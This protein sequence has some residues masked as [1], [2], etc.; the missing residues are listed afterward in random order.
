MVVDRVRR[1]RHV[2]R[3]RRSRQGRREDDI[4]RLVDAIGPGRDAVPGA[5]DE[6]TRLGALLVV[7]TL[8]QWAGLRGDSENSSGAA[9]EAIEPLQRATAAGVG[10]VLVRHD[11]KGSG[12]VGESA[13]GSTAFGGAVDVILQL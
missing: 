8:P 4:P 9:L 13:R 5:G 2:A 12:E 7:D 3:A 1:A 10:V 6:A 11:R